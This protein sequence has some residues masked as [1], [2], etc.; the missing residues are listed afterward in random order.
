MRIALVTVLVLVSMCVRA[1]AQSEPFYPVELT[2]RTVVLPD[3]LTEVDAAVVVPANAGYP[4]GD[5]VGGAVQVR[6]AFKAIEPFA[7]LGLMLVKPSA[8]DVE[9]LSIIGG[10]VR[11][12][13]DD[14]TDIKVAAV[15][16][17]PT[18]KDESTYSATG[19]CE[20]KI[21]ILPSSLSLVGEAGLAVAWSDRHL[22]GMSSSVIGPFGAA[23]LQV[24][25]T[26]AAA[27][28]G[29]A[30]ATVFVAKSAADPRGDAYT[31]DA[32]G[33]ALFG[34]DAFD[35]YL[36]VTVT[37]VANRADAVLAGGAAAR[38]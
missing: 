29:G 1:V 20:V 32:Y 5:V 25:I 13:L 36:R 24:Q 7:A 27:I 2:N 12:R 33:M 8:N 15:S 30:A 21:P 19:S 6:H 23:A 4:L 31:A 9:T 14:K 34:F 22:G 28:E 37:D 16:L 26:P 18:A 11:V 17:E 38:F 3:D 10:G 35:V